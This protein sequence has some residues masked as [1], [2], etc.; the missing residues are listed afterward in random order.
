VAVL[1][2]TLYDLSMFIFSST[3]VYLTR[4]P[5]TLDIVLRFN[6]E[7]LAFSYIFFMILLLTLMFDQIEF[8][9]VCQWT[10]LFMRTSLTLTLDTTHLCPQITV[11]MAAIYW[12]SN[13]IDHY[14]W[15]VGIIEAYFSHISKT[16]H[17]QASSVP[18]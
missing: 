9:W 10:L 14:N 11:L 7:V 16:E 13:D 18:K 6:D 2:L 12:P 3:K 15:S 4:V 17:W 1:S 8:I 5:F